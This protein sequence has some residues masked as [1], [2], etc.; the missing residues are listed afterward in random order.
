M[1][2][3]LLSESVRWLE[4]LSTVTVNRASRRIHLEGFSL[5]AVR[6]S[7]ARVQQFAGWDGTR[8]EV[9]RVDSVVE[10]SSRVTDNIEKVFARIIRPKSF[11]GQSVP[12]RAIDFSFA[13]FADGCGFE[14]ALV[15]K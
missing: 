14:P 6:T 7:D 10:R 3:R 5:S 11:G 4:K 9:L 8:Q 15:V 13:S 2:L 12:N 1:L